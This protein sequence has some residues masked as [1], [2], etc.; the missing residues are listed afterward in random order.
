MLSGTGQVSRDCSDDEVAIWMDVIAAWKVDEQRPKQLVKLIKQ[1]IPE[2]L[3]VEVWQRLCN[4]DSSQDMIDNYK[5]LI[6]KVN[7]TISLYSSEIHWKKIVLIQ[8]INIAG[9][10]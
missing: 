2:A 10:Q 5:L 1:G 9:E 4:C 7:K 3:R 6:T 8:I